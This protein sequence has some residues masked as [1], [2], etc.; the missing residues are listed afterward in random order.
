MEL[1]RSDQLIE[2]RLGVQSEHFCYP[3]G[4]WSATAEPAV[5]GRY[6]TATLGG[7]PR[8]A[9]PPTPIA[10]TAFRSN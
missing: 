7:D 8:L 6:R 3:Y 2:A 9:R 1:A 5:R 4:Y 10:F